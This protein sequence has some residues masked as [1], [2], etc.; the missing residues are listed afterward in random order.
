MILQKS[1][2]EA[3]MKIPAELVKGPWKKQVSIV[4]ITQL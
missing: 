2:F 3:R 1:D 4:Q